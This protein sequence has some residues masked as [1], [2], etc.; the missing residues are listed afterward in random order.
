[1]TEEITLTVGGRNLR[2]WTGMRL[3]RGI[4]RL[5]SDFDLTMTEFAPGDPISL[6]VKPGDSCKVK[7]GDDLVISGFTDRIRPRISPTEHA[8]NVVGRG[9]CADLVDCSAEWPKTQFRNLNA[10]QLAQKLVLPYQRDTG[11]LKVKCTVPTGLPTVP[12]F[13]LM[14]G[15]TSF[16]IIERCARFSSLLAY[17]QP[18]GNLL[19]TRVNETDT[20]ASGFEEGVNVQTGS[21]DIGMD[22]RFSEYF[23]YLQS[24]DLFQDV[25]IGGLLASKALDKTVTRHRRKVVIAESPGSDQGFKVATQRAN[26][27]MAR[28]YGRSFVVNLTVD[29]WRDKAG[30]L[31]T[32]NALAPLDMPSLKLARKN[33]QGIKWTI[34]QV[35]YNL[36]EATGTTAEVTLMPAEAFKVQPTI[37]TPVYGDIEAGAGLRGPQ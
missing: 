5:P 16:E 21:A 29:S 7:L 33:T 23:C 20:H 27:E 19:L 37:I 8:I 31:W 4:E 14:L 9:K 2:G 36:T 1:M 28:R 18:D 15:E 25:G 30:R 10:F 35:T 6:P 12:S 11:G 34:A 13:N 24:V 22:Q 17:D 26:W 32:P 3:T